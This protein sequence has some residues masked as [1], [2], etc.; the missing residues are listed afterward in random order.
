MKTIFCGELNSWKLN[1]IHSLIF[2]LL[3]AQ[4]PILKANYTNLYVQKITPTRVQLKY[5]KT[6]ILDVEKVIDFMD[7]IGIVHSE[8]VIKQALLETGHFKSRF[9]MDKNNLFAFRY[10]KKYISFET[11]QASVIYYKK[12]QDKNYKDHTEDYYHFLRRLKYARSANYIALL[13]KIK[14]TPNK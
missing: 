1:K 2:I 8:I 11:W 4:I 5:Y 14:I 12:W 10:T 7:S 6:P 3:I 9:L 13:K